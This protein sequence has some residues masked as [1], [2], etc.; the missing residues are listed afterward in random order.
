[1]KRSHLIGGLLSLL[2][3]CISAEGLHALDS[4]KVTPPENATATTE[5]QDSAYSLPFLNSGEMPDL[6][7][8]EFMADSLK[9]AGTYF[10]NNNIKALPKKLLI[11]HKINLRP[12]F[13]AR[14]RLIY[15]TG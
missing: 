3:Q 7:I 10:N 6:N 12:I 4:D 5:Q 13:P 11:T 14:W 8:R 2:A 9:T 1:M 15:R